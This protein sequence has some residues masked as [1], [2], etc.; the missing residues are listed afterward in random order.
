M[1]K[2]L[3]LAAALS[4]T[5]AFFVLLFAAA[6]GAGVAVLRD[7]QAAIEALGRGNIER[8]SD[9]GDTTSWLFQARAVLADAKTYM[10]GGLE[11]QRDAALAQAA[12]LLEQ[13]RASQ[14][15]LRANPEMA[16]QGAS[17]YDEV[18]AGYDALAVQA[19][20]PLHAAL[21]GWNGIE[22]NRLAERALPQAAERYIEAVDAFQGYARE[23]GRA[24]VADAA[25]VLERMV[26]G[27]A[28]LL[29]LV[30]VLAVVIRLGFRR[31]MLRPLTEAG[32]HFDRI[33]DGD[34]TAAIAARGDNEIGVL[35]SAMRRMQGGL[36]RAVESVRHGVE[37]IHTGSG[38]IAAGGVEMS[39]RTARQAGALQEAAATELARQGGT[40]VAQV[41]ASMRDIASGAQRIAEI[42]GLV[43]SL[44]FQ[45]NVL[46]LNAAVEA[47]RAGPQGRGF[48]VVA[49]EVRSL[50]QRSAQAAREIKGLIDDSS[51]RVASGVQQVNLAGATMGEIVQS[52]DRVTQL[53]A[54]ISEASATQAAGIA[55]VNLAVADA[56]RATQE[57]A[58]M[59]E[60]TAAA[61]ASL[62][63]QAQA[64]RQAVA[65]FR[66]AGAAPRSGGAGGQLV[67]LDHQRQVAVLDLLLDAGGGRGE[68]L[69]ANVAA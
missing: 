57:N 4:A 39:G 30:A 47:A 16:A 67:A 36:T 68:V 22:A 55:S 11:E 12:T 37:E 21:K 25:R 13:A 23:Q 33:A 41:V 1:R 46:A 20:A 44:A 5:L 14:E 24:A 69:R 50:A 63:A 8:A 7:N 27:A 10:E 65:V 52:I 45:T 19:L 29:A 62:E 38:E 31:A 35:Y 48:A 3:K 66:L 54:G 6:A 34:L 28:A 58:A 49:G 42:V 15:R 60:Q 43:D 18:L 64:L 2:K 32:R 59:A 53:V 51:A 9:L 56:E 61:A 40:A 26:L 17:L